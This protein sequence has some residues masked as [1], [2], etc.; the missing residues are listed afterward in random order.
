MKDPYEAQA[1]ILFAGVIAES[2]VTGRMNWGGATQ[3][4]IAIRSMARRS[5]SNDKQAE[6]LQQKWWDKT[7]YWFDDPFWKIVDVIAKEL[8]EK[9]SLS[10]RAVRHWFDQLAP[11]E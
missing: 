1:M 11:K 6:K 9:R 4:L 3:D 2:K 10:G 5:T 7:E 8:I